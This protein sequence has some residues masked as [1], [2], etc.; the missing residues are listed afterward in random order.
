ME[1]SLNGLP[2]TRC[3]ILA[4]R[5]GAWAADVA[6]D[7]ETDIA[8]AVSLVVEGVTLRGAVVRGGVVYG[9]WSGRVVGGVGGLLAPVAPVAQYTTTLAVALA[10]VLR[11][12]GE[13]L[14]A[15]SGDL[16]TNVTRWH[17]AAGTA[18]NAVADVARAA[19][20]AWRVLAD[21]TVWVG[22]ETW[23]AATVSG[24]ELLDWRPE[25]G[26]AELGGDAAALLGIL[27]GQTLTLDAITLRA[28]CVEHRIDAGE[29]RTV[30]FAEPAE[31]PSGRFV[32]A[33]ARLV[34]ALTRRVDYLG[35]FPARVV[36][37]HA[38]GTLDLRPDDESRLAS[39]TRVPLRHG[40]P[41]VTAVSVAAGTR[42]RLAFDAGD[43]ARPYA[44]LWDAG[45]ATSLTF[46]G[47]ARRFARTNDTSACGTLITVAGSVVSYIP[48]G[49]PLPDPLPVGGTAIALSGV[50]TGTSD[51]RG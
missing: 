30:V 22:A 18:A 26:R 27:P 15:T 8:G 25:L 47:S 19:G 3:T 16:S 50:I 28:G 43:P 21:G 2:V 10:D 40:L 33:L 17:R 9:R 1:V 45:N 7:T 38:D 35:T 20:F 13:A 49:T 46:N 41:G 6:V 24:V 29:I 14:A 12:A 31:K 48:P 32:D 42:V 39:C 23:P 5:I 4:P 37:Q 11:E 36:Q 34:A 51:L 44:A